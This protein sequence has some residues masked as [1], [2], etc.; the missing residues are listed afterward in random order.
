MELDD[1]RWAAFTRES[2]G[3]TPFHHPAWAQVLSTV[4][5]FPGFV[6]A[7]TGDGGAVT[8]GA[9]FLEPAHP[10]RPPRWVSLPFTDECPPLA[11]SPDHKRALL[12]DVERAAEAAGVRRIELR[13]PAG[14]ERWNG[15]ADAVTHVLELSADADEA[16]RRFSR[17]QVVRNIRRADREGVEVR[18][19]TSDAH[20]ESFY[21]LHT[22]TRRRQG[23][24]VQPR[25]FFGLL[26]RRILAAGL[27]EILLAYV[28]EVP[29]AGAVFLS[30]NGT[31]VYK[32]GASDPHAW[33]RRPNHALFWTAVQRACARGDRRFDFG[34]TDSANAGLRAFKAGWGA[35]ERPLVYSVMPR[36]RHAERDGFATRALGGAIRRGP[37][38]VCRAAGEALYRYAA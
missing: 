7:S 37:I 25:A 5:G 4:Y 28:G 11:A 17:S 21:T 36:A 27:G 10:L 38:W 26:G 3:A 23:V 30:W 14:D 8:A 24:P 2:P 12:S 1:P 19:G 6:I 22:R 35:V 15:R 20:L 16:R 13:A 34:R 18:A 33:G 29:V 31:T 9:P 32:Y